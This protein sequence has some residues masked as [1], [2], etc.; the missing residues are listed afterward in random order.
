MGKPTWKWSSA[1]F[2][3]S[4][5]PACSKFAQNKWKWRQVETTYGHSWSRQVHRLQVSRRTVPVYRFISRVCINVNG[6]E[7]QPSTELRRIEQ[8]GVSQAEQ[9]RRRKTDRNSE[10]ECCTQKQRRPPPT[11]QNPRPVATNDSFVPLRDL[12]MKNSETRSEVNFTK[13]RTKVCHLPS[14]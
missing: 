4:N 12:P 8:E 5:R 9:N 14:Y 1:S 7:G 13:T 11:Y 6:N 10:D 3:I 2:C